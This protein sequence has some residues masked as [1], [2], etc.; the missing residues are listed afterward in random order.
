MSQAFATAAL[1]IQHAALGHGRG[2]RFI[3]TGKMQ[4]GKSEVD[5]RIARINA[6]RPLQQGLGS[7]IIPRLLCL[8]GT[9]K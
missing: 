9:A 3:T 8:L 4:A 6:L 2:T 1:T 7:I 5:L